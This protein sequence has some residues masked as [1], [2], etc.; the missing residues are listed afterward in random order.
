M[1]HCIGD[2]HASIFSG[3]ER[4]QPKWPER[5]NDT[6]EHFRSYRI[7]P[8]TAYQLKDKRPILD[9]IL[10]LVDKDN[11]S[12]LFCFG[13]VDVR[14]HLKKQM[15]IQKRSAKDIVTECVDRYFDTV[16]HYKNLG[17]NVMIWGPIASWHNSKPY[18][19]PTFGTNLE[20]NEIAGIFN[21]YSKLLCINNG[22]TF[23]SIFSKML[24]DNG[25]TNS[26]YLDGTGIHLSNNTL[27]LIDEQF[28]MQGLI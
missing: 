26:T 19:G 15:D 25:E 4:Q 5:S 11:D 18:N 20:R 9:N 16:L 8:A 22:I 14:A 17:Y 27:P 1:I 7:G 12:V 23:V 10:T 3:N 6:L 24:L 13:E 28:K 21:E 2:S